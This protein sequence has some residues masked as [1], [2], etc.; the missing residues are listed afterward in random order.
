M[1]K[2]IMPALITPI[3]EK[4]GI[5]SPVLKKLVC[6]LMG[7]GADGFYLCG[8]TGE[9]LNLT[10]TQHK[11]MVRQ[12]IEI[13]DGKVPCIVHV[14]RTVYSEMIELARYAES[15][16]ATALSAIPPIFFK[17]DEDEIY[18]YYERLANSVKIPIVIY[19]SPAAAVAFSNNLLDRLFSIPNLKSIKWTSPNYATVMSA[20]ARIPKANFINGPDEMLL[21][22]LA[23][24][25]DAGIGTTYNFLLPEIKEIY[26]DFM[27]GDMVKAREKQAHVA[28][29][30]EV[31]Q[32]RSII[33]TTKFIMSRL[34]Y[35]VYYPIHP[36]RRLTAEE[37]Q[38]VITY[39]K[40]VGMDIR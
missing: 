7:G 15:V 33:M 25:C 30:C 14:A 1:F 27:S 9:G 32:G 29:L 19:N 37:E 3:N 34:G 4:G 26:N 10:V 36:M 17:Y 20:K 23:A 39:L 35:D 38:G 12:T 21:Q 40:S 31:F 28:Q 6:D 8:A 16:G 2:G 11:E 18:S 24:G 5:N 22:G 13:V